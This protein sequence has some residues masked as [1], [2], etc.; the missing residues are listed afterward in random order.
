MSIKLLS[1]TIGFLPLP[2]LTI[3]CKRLEQGHVAQVELKDESKIVESL[4]LNRHL[5]SQMSPFCETLVLGLVNKETAQQQ[6][7]QTSL[8]LSNSPYV[9]EL[10]SGCWR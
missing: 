1:V 4:H 3:T 7:V 2:N 8:D 10:F 9:F 6:E 5:L